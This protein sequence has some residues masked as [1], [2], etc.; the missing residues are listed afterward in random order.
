M[1]D[2]KKV[3]EMLAAGAR[4]TEIA[5]EV[6]CSRDTVYRIRGEMPMA[7]DK[8]KRGPPR[9][10]LLS[11]EE[12]AL[13]FMWRDG[14]PASEIAARLHA[15]IRTVSRYVHGLEKQKKEREERE[16]NRH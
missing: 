6:G 15:S 3:E 5:N 8:S 16:A 1:V 2:R 9:R 14:V 10:R 13:E 7:P 4:V 11:W 12:H